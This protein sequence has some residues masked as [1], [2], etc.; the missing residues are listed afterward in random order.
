MK[1]TRRWH[2]A[3]SGCALGV[4]LALWCST[5][6]VELFG[7]TEQVVRLKTAVP[8]VLLVLIPAL[9]LTGIT[10]AKL[11]GGRTTGVLGVKLLRM[12]LIAAN[13]VIVLTP[14]A[15][16][17]AYKA[18]S[19]ELDAAFSAVQLLELCAGA[20]NLM[21]MALNAR[22]GLRLGRAR[23]GSPAAVRPRRRRRSLVVQQRG[24]AGPWR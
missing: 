16:Y 21:L 10:G 7:R 12:K 24:G 13:G 19:G 8:W 3:A 6:W 18:T 11:A 15:L 17:L 1:R 2:R 23:P 4:L 22:D 9:A 5:A 14:A 20:V